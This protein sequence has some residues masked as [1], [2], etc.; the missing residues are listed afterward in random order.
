MYQWVVCGNLNEISG[1]LFPG[2]LWPVL[3]LGGIPHA[4]CFF[5]SI[6][7][8]VRLNFSFNIL[9]KS[10]LQTLWPASSLVQ[11]TEFSEQAFLFG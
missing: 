10:F 6:I 7:C 8:W 9:M 2:V 11:L 5:L 1:S 3:S 4:D